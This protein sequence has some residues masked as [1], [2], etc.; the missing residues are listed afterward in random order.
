MIANKHT[1]NACFLCDP[2]SH[3][4]R[5]VP[6]QDALVRTPLWSTMMKGFPSGNG[7]REPKQADRNNS[8]K[9]PLFHLVSICPPPSNGHFTPPS[10]QSDY[11]ANEGWRWQEE[12]CA[13]ADCHPWDS[14]AKQYAFQN[15][16]PLPSSPTPPVASKNATT[17]SPL[18]PSSPHSNNE[19]LQEFTNLQPMLMI[20]QVINQ[21]LLEHFQLLHMIP[22]E[23]VAHQNEMHQE[24]PEE[25]NS[26]LGN[27]LGPIK[28]RKSQ[29]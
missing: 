15:P 6:S 18:V 12:I 24:F 4:A 7:L 9:F 16:P 19:S 5:G 29:G 17:P 2:S 8:G 11:P 13:W 3:V 22:F 10:E 23:D 21:I 1:R 25:L 28:W 20:P 27:S 14:N 26:L